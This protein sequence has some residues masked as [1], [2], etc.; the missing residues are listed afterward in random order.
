MKMK[1]LQKVTKA[2]N[3][4]NR[5]MQFCTEG[6]ITLSGEEELIFHRWN[7]AHKLWLQ[8]KYTEQQIAEKVKELHGVSIFTA[9]NDIYQAMALFGGSIRANKKFL[10]HHHAESIFLFMERCKVDKTL[11]HLV[12]KLADAYTKAVV[13]MPDEINKDQKQSPQFVFV[14]KEGQGLSVAKNYEEAV[15]NM[16]KRLLNDVTDIAHEEMTDE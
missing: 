3:T 15:A 14:V 9:R 5:I 1:E 4:F 6:D 10:L 12:P 7:S 11:V 8:K 16:K 13:S 2:E